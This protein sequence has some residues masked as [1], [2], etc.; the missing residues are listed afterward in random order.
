MMDIFNMLGGMGQAQQTVSRQLGTS[1]HQTEAAM[2]AALPLLLGA[3]TRNAQTP[4]GAAALSGA[5]D[6]HDGRALDLFGQGQVPDPQ[7]GQKILGHLFGNQQHAAANAV[8]RRA[9]IDPQM[10]MQ[11]LMMLA[12]LVLNYLG[13]LRQGQPGGS[14]QGDNAGTGG[15]GFDIGSILGGLLGG[16]MGS[17]T[18]NGYAQRTQVPDDQSGG[19][20]GGGPVIPGLPSQDEPTGQ[21]HRPQPPMGQQANTGGLIGTLNNVLDRD[22]DGNALD[23][24]IGMFGGQRR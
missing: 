21:W 12:P 5:L 16:G 19:V 13:R 3:L 17:G 15:G 2:E 8:S 20:L 7:D 10:A 23:D 4:E 9:G 24:L 11:V 18:G 6:R 1:P 14:R 22:G